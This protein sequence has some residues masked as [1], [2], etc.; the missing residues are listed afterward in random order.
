M[1]LDKPLEKKVL[2][3]LYNLGLTTEEAKIYIFLLQNGP[4][5]VLAV[6][7]GLKTGRTKLYPVLDK[8]TDK[9]LVITKERH[10]GQTYEA[11]RPEV[12]EFLVSEHES[13]A[14]QLR[15]SLAAVTNVLQRIQLQAP[16]TSKV[17]EYR[18]VE[19]L[20]QMNWNIGRAKGEYRTFELD[21]LKGHFSRHFDDKFYRRQVDHK[22]VSYDL[23]NNPH[24]E[25]E[26]K[27]PWDKKYFH[28]GYISPEVFKIAFEMTIYNN[29]VAL[30]NYE[31]GDILGVEIYNDNLAAQQVQVFN[32]LWKQSTPLGTKDLS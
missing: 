20:K 9:Q 10:Y 21:R 3:Y 5:S 6:S 24:R 12:L 27:S 29:C 25:S 30:F 1:N 26:V 22:I 11:Q 18:G 7:R 17:V 14:E 31:A 23:T 4:Q 15:N 2:L 16:N 32:L 13:K 8:L 28:M 19:G